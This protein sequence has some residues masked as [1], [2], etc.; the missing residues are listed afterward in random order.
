MLDQLLNSILF[1]LID[2][3]MLI[4]EFNSTL[5]WLGCISI[6]IVLFARNKKTFEKNAIPILT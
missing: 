4:I 6:L 2:F 1:L 3:K 5:F